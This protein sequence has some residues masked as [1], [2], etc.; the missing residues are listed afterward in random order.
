V[1]Q[2]EQVVQQELLERLNHLEQHL[3]SGTSGT[4][5]IS[6][7]FARNYSINTLKHN[8]IYF[9]KIITKVLELKQLPLLI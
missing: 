4:S 7:N 5:G 2:V 9:Y 1:E 3:L 8:M 6:F